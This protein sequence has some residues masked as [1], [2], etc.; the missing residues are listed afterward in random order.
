[1]QR[2]TLS[3]VSALEISRRISAPTERI[4]SVITDLDAA[5]DQ[6]SGVE[7]IERISGPEFGV[8]TRWRET[9]RM[10]GKEAVEE[11]EVGTVIPERSYTVEAASHGSKYHSEL[12]VEGV[13]DGTSL[14]TMSFEAE[15]QSLGAKLAS[16][17]I[18]LL[19][20]GATKKALAKDL[21][22]I[23]AAAEAVY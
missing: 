8:G 18:G 2:G 22:D 12:T 5:P 7:S 10:F 6:L 14:L 15:P 17:T 4:W 9:R 23:A 11:L 21:D 16:A 20:R 3:A 1:M 13:G 19:F